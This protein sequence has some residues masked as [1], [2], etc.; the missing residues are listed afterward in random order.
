V[1]PA[2]R[3]LGWS[4]GLVS[5]AGLL[6]VAYPTVRDNAELDK[7]FTSLSP[8][9]QALLGLGDGLALTSPAGYLNSQFFANVLPVM[10][11][12]FAVGTA[13]WA[14]AGDEAAGTLELLLANPVG[15]ARVAIARAA[16]LALLLGVLT[17]VCAA[18]LAAMAPAA[19]L[20]QG[21][22]P[23][24]LVHA[25]VAC[26]ALAL[27]FAAVAFA[28]GAAT[29]S[30]PAAL[31]VASA[32]AV[33]GYLVEGLA[34]QVRALRPVRAASPWHWLL[35]SDPLRHGLAWQAW[36]LPL[37]VSALLVLLGT[38]RLARRDLR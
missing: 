8:G 3:L 37:G 29:G 11:L 5:V 12:V 10:L 17:A 20:D 1:A 23:L 25:T 38:L 24:R 33:V 28:V 35:G 36:A 31:A 19:G 22:P 34:A 6:A 18:A 13:A 15:R 2:P 9:V 27:A 26:G 16:A 14:V 7:T 21:L 4:L 30:R 32:L